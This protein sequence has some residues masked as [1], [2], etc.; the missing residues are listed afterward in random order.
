MP[1][2]Y[3]YREVKQ[4]P[5]DAITVK[6]YAEARNCHHSLIYHEL[7]RGKANFEI[8]NFQGINFVTTSS[9]TKSLK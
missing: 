8:I 2:L 5:K 6:A 4:L 7:K 9:F 1:R 3:K